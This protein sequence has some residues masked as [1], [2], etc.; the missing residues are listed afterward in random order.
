MSTPY[1]RPSMFANQRRN[2][3]ILLAVPL[4][5]SGKRANGT[6]FAE[7]TNTLIGN[8]HGALAVLRE[9]VREGQTLAVKNVTTGEEL[10]CTVVDVNPGAN[11]V[12]EIGLEFAKPNPRFWRVSFLPADWSTRSPEA[13]RF[14]SGPNDTTHSTKTPAVKK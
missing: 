14:A 5:V 3:R 4:R 1:I 10:A 2:Q 13:K 12:P 9:P 8:A 11:G 7:H 6:A